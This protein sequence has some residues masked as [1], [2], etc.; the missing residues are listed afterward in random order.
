MGGAILSVQS[1]IVTACGLMENNNA[2]GHGGGIASIDKALLFL[3]QGS[4]FLGNKAG[5]SG[6]CV[7][8]AG[9]DVTFG[10]LETVREKLSF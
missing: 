3:G 1:S 9:S 10:E 6:G 7:Y 8:A 5:G 4:V 2:I